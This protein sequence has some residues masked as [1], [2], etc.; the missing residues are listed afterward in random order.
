MLSN[1]LCTLQNKVN[2]WSVLE[3]FDKAF[4][5]YKSVQFLC[6]IHFLI[7]II[8]MYIHYKKSFHVQTDFPMS[9][10]ILKV[11]DNSYEL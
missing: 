8:F 6:P 1:L 2:N 3:Y 9:E 11:T 10:L 7:L 4:V 5:S